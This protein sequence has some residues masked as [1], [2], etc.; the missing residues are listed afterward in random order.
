MLASL[1]PPAP[2]TGPP[3]Q[4]GVTFRYNPGLYGC[5]PG[6][7]GGR[8]GRI[9]CIWGCG[10]CAPTRVKRGCR[11]HC[12]FLL[13]A[14]QEGGKKKCQAQCSVSNGRLPVVHGCLSS[15][16]PAVC[17]AGEA[18]AGAPRPGE[19]KT[20]RGGLH[21]RLDGVRARSGAQ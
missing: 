15:P 3:S 12:R 8:A 11:G 6:G 17:R 4:S 19:E 14:F 7:A 20:H 2:T 9:G 1:N 10:V 16:L 18:G 13:C 5:G 21:P